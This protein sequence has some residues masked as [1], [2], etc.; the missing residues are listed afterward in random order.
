MLIQMTELPY[1]S[2]EAFVN[3]KN[4]HTG[5]MQ[6]VYAPDSNPSPDERAIQRTSEPQPA[7]V[8]MQPDRSGENAGLPEP[9]MPS[10]KTPQQSRV[11][12]DGQYQIDYFTS[13][14]ASI[15]Q[16][17]SILSFEDWT[18]DIEDVASYED[19]AEQ[20]QLALPSKERSAIKKWVADNG[21]DSSDDI[22]YF[23]VQTA[24]DGQDTKAMTRRAE[25][26]SGLSKMPAA[27]AKLL[28][29][30][31]VTVDVAGN[32]VYNTQI[33]P[34]DFL[35]N[36]NR[37]LSAS[38]DNTYAINNDQVEGSGIGVQRDRQPLRAAVARQ[39]RQ[40]RRVRVAFMPN[41]VFAVDGI[42][43][44]NPAG[45]ANEPQRIALK[46]R[47]VDA[48]SVNGPIK[49]IITGEPRTSA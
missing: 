48:A 34:G 49:D 47:E 8:E 11:T 38:H 24:Y 25:L 37:F 20:A 35:S 2:S 7:D 12:A 33:G 19:E 6:R 27:P 41:R 28:R 32:T 13:G 4:L 43:V 15:E 21:S 45:A 40:R 1:D 22:H 10:V 31:S 5:Q 23:E 9:G 42:A 30:A 14:Q 46:L 44:R 17:D 26:E 29:V 36:G 3:V 39:R 16:L 18:T